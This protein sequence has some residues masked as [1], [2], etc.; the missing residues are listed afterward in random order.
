MING[1]AAR[2]D[3]AF[4]RPFSVHR[5]DRTAIF[6]GSFPETEEDMLCLQDLGVSAVLCIQTATDMTNFGLAWKDQLQMF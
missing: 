4:K 2:F 5:L 6:C 3:G 1:K